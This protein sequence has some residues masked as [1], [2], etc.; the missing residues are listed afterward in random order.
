VKNINSSS[1]Q[2]WEVIMPEANQSV[3]K[4]VSIEKNT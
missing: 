1:T 2:N 4:E 3:Q